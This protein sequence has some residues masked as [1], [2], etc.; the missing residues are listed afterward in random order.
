M[1]LRT[2]PHLAEAFGVVAGLSDHT[3]GLAVP[4]AAVA[5][6]ACIIEKHLTLSRAAGGPDSG[7]SL[8]PEE[9]KAMVKAVREAEQARG[10]VR[11]TLTEEEEA[12]RVFRRS[13]CG[14]DVLAVN[15][16]AT[17]FWPSHGLAPRYFEMVLGRR[18]V[19]N[20]E[21]GTPLA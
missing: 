16:S 11:Y 13:L 18:A 10:E 20:I 8:E 15:H 21:K 4:V 14:R 7:F 19:R 6:G 9:F 2:I 12:S 3:L 1:N 17:M 5:L